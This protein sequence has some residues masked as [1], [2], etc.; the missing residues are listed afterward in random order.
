MTSCFVSFQ[1]ILFHFYSSYFID[2]HWKILLKAKPLKVVKIWL[3]V[4]PKQVL[5]AMMK[6]FTCQS[7]HS[8][9]GPFQLFTDSTKELVLFILAN[10][11]KKS[12][13]YLLHHHFHPIQSPIRLFYSL[14]ISVDLFLL[15]CFSVHL[16]QKYRF[17]EQ[18]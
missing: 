6:C 11:W 4:M 7:K 14:F 12:V 3:A 13:F 16:R 1:K 18:N 15:T 17:Q 10:F 9:Q 8:Y 5:M 2:Y